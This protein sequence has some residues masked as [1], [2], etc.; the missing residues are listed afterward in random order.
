MGEQ[1]LEQAIKQYRSGHKRVRAQTL[2]PTDNISALS[3]MLATL[4]QTVLGGLVTPSPPPG[5]YSPSRRWA[6]RPPSPL[7]GARV[8]HRR[9]LASD[10]ATA[11]RRKFNSGA[12]ETDHYA[13]CH[14]ITACASLSCAKMFLKSTNFVS[15]VDQR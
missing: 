13:F 7:G 14:W 3:F 4:P 8:S 2:T 10:G 5:C 12:L 11:R 6:A 15:K 1:Q 9:A